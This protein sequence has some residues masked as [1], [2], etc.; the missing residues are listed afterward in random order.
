MTR[1]R[2]A[3]LPGLACLVVGAAGWASRA[4]L[5]EVIV[6][7][8]RQRI[9]LVPSWQPL[10]AFLVLAAVVLAGVVVA[11][12]R[13]RSTSPPALATLVL[14]TFGLAALAVPYLPVVPDWWPA[15]QALAGPGLWMI[16]ALV[17]AQLVWTAW[18]HLGGLATWCA[19]RRLLTQTA[20]IWLVTA[21]AAGLTASRLTSTP[22]F[23]SGDEPH[24]LIMAQSLGVDGNLRI[25]NNHQTRD[26]AA[27]FGRDLDPHYLTRGRDGEIYSVHPV[28]MPVLITPVYALGGYQLVVAFFVAMAA[29]AATLMWRWAVALAGTLGTPTLAWAAITLSAPFLVNAVT[30]YPEVPAALVVA[31]AIVL[32]LRVTPDARPW[33]DIVIGLLAG[34]L[35]WLSTKYAPM[36]AAL[37]AV[38]LGR[39]VWPLHAGE[40]RWNV[41]GALRLAAPYGLSLLGWFAFF[42]AYWGTP[43]PSAPYGAMVQTE[44]AN[45]VFGVPGLL[46]DQEYGLLVYAPAY[47]LA[48]AGFWAMM[49]RPGPLRRVGLELLLVFAALIGTVGAF[50]IWWGGSGAPA[51]PLMSGLL[52]L[53]LP[54]TVQLGT[55]AAGSARRAAQHLLVWSGVCLSAVLVLEES[56]F[57]LA[58]G[59]DGTST[60]LAW[61]SPR[62]PLW[63]LVPTFIEHEAGRALIDV[64]AWVV[65]AAVASWALA[66]VTVRTRGAASLVAL[67]A[68][69]ATL[70]AGSTAMRLLPAADPPLPGIDL[71]ARAR[72]PALDTFDHRIRPLAVHY[73][74]FSVESAMASGVESSLSVGAAPGLRPEPQPLRVIHN[75]RFS[76]PAGHYR[77]VIQWAA[78]DPLPAPAGAQV[79]LQVGRI[80]A[81]L[82]TWTVTPVPNGVWSEAFWLP[83]D[84][85]F[86]GLRGTS[87]VERSIASLRFEAVDIVDL[88]ARPRTPP[89]LAAAAYGDALVLFHDET[90]YPESEGFWTT[91][92]RPAR[93][94]VACPNGCT[95]GISLRVH[96]GK[97]P[98]HLRVASSG[99]SHEV[100]LQGEAAV[101]IPV[102][103]PASGGVIQLEFTTSTGFVP[104]DVD[105]ATRDRRYL[106]VWITPAVTAKETP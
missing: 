9:A 54:L 27:Y 49:R 34:T 63:R 51:R 101:D 48:G 47:V 41:A 70:V 97:R 56:G 73:A 10:L 26:Y 65:I 67:A 53:L 93:I 78:R 11:R 84:S 6:G 74:P 40:A 39:R 4:E 61:L 35:P 16:W 24:Y 96:S 86:V 3:L 91:G 7:G 36:S 52:V 62:W 58:N 18:P 29:T 44:I 100:D 2:A 50:R 37:M 60:L 17:A 38:A 77:A 8:T 64:G 20:A 21:A 89:V 80:G 75:G 79:G 85:G 28:G 88:G 1:I 95:G 76:L 59:R 71:A 81:A 83:V 43:M 90:T 98:N 105:P 30:I 15:L 12:S 33:H 42:Y 103:A 32:A 13:R 69:A 106:G 92:Q 102:P 104:I 66:R 14:P 46:F 57:L 5:D 25:E 68:G 22:L 72:L 55:A 82:T 87:D 23:P 31:L 45:T 94:S 99:W 19:S